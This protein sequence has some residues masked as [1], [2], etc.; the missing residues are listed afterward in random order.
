MQAKRHIM[1]KLGLVCS[2]AA[3]LMVSGCAIWQEKGPERYGLA[4]GA[5][6]IPVMNPGGEMSPPDVSQAQQQPSALGQSQQFASQSAMAVPASVAPMMAPPVAYAPPPPQSFVAPPPVVYA[7]TAM[8]LPPQAGGYAN[9]QPMQAMQAPTPQNSYDQEPFDLASTSLDRNA[10]YPSLSQV[11]QA[12]AMSADRVANAQN[13]AN[14]LQQELNQSQAQR[15]SA[16]QQVAYDGTPW[17][18]AP[19]QPMQAPAPMMAPP[20]AGYPMASAPQVMV[21]QSSGSMSLEEI[22]RRFAGPRAPQDSSAAL[23]SATNYQLQPPQPQMAAPFPPREVLKM[24]PSLSQPVPEDMTAIAQSYAFPSPD[25]TFRM[26]GPSSMPAAPTEELAPI[27]LIP[28]TPEVNEGT[29]ALDVPPARTRFIAEPPALDVP[30]AEEIYVP[31]APSVASAPNGWDEFSTPA[32]NAIVLTPPPEMYQGRAQGFLPDSRY[33]K[34]RRFQR[35][36]I[37]F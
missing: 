19:Q 6:R 33:E 28:P 3:F 10:G 24:P 15:M 34:R 36:K 5:K 12:P 18:A 31:P 20:P 14:A 23:P 21:S 25:A 1:T 30:A 8:P 32:G 13:A 2:T 17:A 37:R 7:P 16:Q 26:T 11:P 27:K 29:I 9:P 22:D 35:R 4:P